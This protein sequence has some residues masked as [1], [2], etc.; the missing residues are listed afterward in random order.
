[1]ILIHGTE[2]TRNM[3]SG[4]M[5]AIFIKDANKLDKEEFTDVMKEAKR[6]IALVFWNHPGWKA[7]A[8][9]STRWYDMHKWLYERGYI[10]GIEVANYN[11]WYPEAIKWCNENLSF[12]VKQRKLIIQ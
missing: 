1:M 12:Y 10:Q 8:F 7:Q 11:T 4:H 9:D 3:P 2:I 5:N 6:Q